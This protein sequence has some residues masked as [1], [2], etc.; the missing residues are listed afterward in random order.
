MKDDPDSATKYKPSSPIETRCRE[1]LA[2]LQDRGLTIGQISAQAAIAEHDLQNIAHG[3]P[4]TPLIGER[5]KQL[6]TAPAEDRSVE[7]PAHYTHSKIEPLDAI[8]AWELP[9]HLA[10]VVKYCARAA[11]KGDE[12]QDCKK[13]RVYLDRYIG[14]LASR[15]QK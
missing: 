4:G 13:A 10:C 6:L 8:E 14:L 7:A 9:H 5:L 15:T 2:G 1:L 12:L 3:H 11:H